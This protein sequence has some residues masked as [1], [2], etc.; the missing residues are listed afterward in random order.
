LSGVDAVRMFKHKRTEG[1]NPQTTLY[2]GSLSGWAAKLVRA[3][4]GNAENP[5]KKIFAPVSSQKAGEQLHRYAERYS[6]AIG[7]PLNIVRVDSKT[8]D[9]G[10]FAELFG[11]PNEWLE[12]SGVDL[13]IA[14]PSIPSGVSFDAEFGYF[15]EVWSAFTSGTPSMW[16]QQQA[17]VRADVPR[18]L[19]IKPFIQAGDMFEASCSERNAN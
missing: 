19:F 14:S 11:N 8:N 15:D 9:F 13:L 17:R 5:G 16:A 12:S 18:H 7:R 3:S 4:V 6:A 1:F 10:D 2:Q